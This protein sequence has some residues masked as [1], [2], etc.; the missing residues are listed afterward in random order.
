[1]GE[2]SKIYD[3]DSPRR[4]S[5]SVG[6][7]DEDPKL[8]NEAS[9]DASTETPNISEQEAQGE[10]ADGVGGAAS[11]EA[12]ALGDRVGSGYNTEDVK[13]LQSLKKF[14]AGATGGKKKKLI[15]AGLIGGG[16]GGLILAAFMAFLPLKINHIMENLQ[17]RF[18]ASS[19]SAVQ[20]RAERLLD[21]YLRDKVIPNLG[22]GTCS[23]SSGTIDKN[24]IANLEGDS[25]AARLFRGWRDARLENKLSEKY[26]IEITRDGFSGGASD[27]KIK[28][29]DKVSN[30]D[31]E[32]WRKDPNQGMWKAAGGRN[33]VRIKVRESFKEETL[34]KRVMYRF[35]VGRLL[36]EKYGI[37]RCVF[38]CKSKD[39]IDDWKDKKK[40]A[41]R[42]V[43]NRRVIIP[44]TQHLGFVLECI[45]D[46]ACDS[47]KASKGEADNDGVRR[48][49]IEKQIREALEK[50]G[51]EFT[52][53][54]VE[55]I[56]EKTIKLADKSLTAFIVEEVV[57]KIAGEAAGS[58]A[59][60]GLPVIGW[61]DLAARITAKAKSAGPALK[62]WKYE[63]I[64][65]QMVATYM[66][67]RTTADECKGMHCNV[68]L[69]G[70]MTNGVG[71]SAGDKDHKNQPAELAPLYGD[72][73]GE[74]IQKSSF[75]DVLSPQKAYAA[76]TGSTASEPKYTCD[77]KNKP[78]TGKLICPE[79]S[80]LT[81]GVIQKISDIFN[82]PPLSLLGQTADA[83]NATIGQILNL[84]NKL[85]D[86]GVGAV[87]A[88]I[89][90]I[91]P[92]YAD[93]KKMIEEQIGKI[94]ETIAKWLIPSPVSADMS[95]ART[96]DMLA[97]GADVAGNNDAHYGLGGIRLT[98]AQVAEIRADQ[99]NQRNEEFQRQP[100]FAR[101]FSTE[102]PKSLVSQM[103]MA[104]PSSV[105]RTAN[106]GV[107]GLLANPF[108]SLSKSFG[109]LLATK[110]TFAADAKPDP[111]GVVQYG[112]PKNSSALD[113]DPDTLTD[114]VCEKMDKDWANGRGEFAGTLI[115]DKETGTDVHTKENPCLLNKKAVAAAGGRYTTDVLDPE[116]Y[117]SETTSGGGGSNSGGGNN[118][119]YVVGDSLTNG[120]K[121][122]GSLTN[123]L[124]TAGWEVTKVQATDG[125]DVDR[126][127]EKIDLDRNEVS[128]A[129]TIAVMLGTNPGPDSP[130]F[131]SKIKLMVD[132]IH[133]YNPSA[134]IFW[135]NAKTQISNYDAVAAAV[136]S[137][138]AALKYTP[139]DW[140]AE[141]AKNPAKYPFAPDKIH[142]TAAGYLAKSDFL[143]ASLGPPPASTGGTGDGT[144]ASGTKNVGL[145]DGYEG[146]V[147]KKITLCAILGFPS[148]SEESNPRSQYYVNGADGN[149][150]VAADKSND[151]VN[152]FN[153]MKSDGVSPKASSSFRT[154][155]HQQELCAKD[156]KCPNGVY[157]DVAKPGTSRHQS[158][159]A[160]DFALTRV[161][162]PEEFGTKN[163]GKASPSNPRVAPGM[164]MWDWLID[165][166]GKYNLKQYWNEP[167]HWSHTGS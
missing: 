15:G 145:A 123:K 142:H 36:E 55:K 98:D 99:E 64:G 53:E 22:K 95:G 83:W 114:A 1:M 85:I 84:I 59:S 79:E 155:K 138:A 62:R 63:I 2:P 105:T 43:I 17:S 70:S 130:Q 119:V 158:G 50:S 97:G 34:W 61:I 167:W 126:S 135:M 109:S 102:S 37:R 101:M 107:T 73:L 137:Q 110:K 163:G 14:L 88:A 94:F 46:P 162:H 131:A 166:A 3:D 164:P 165:N 146:G 6:G 147:L 160:V 72:I 103:A 58:A 76:E 41:F 16:I 92:Q 118:A 132:K 31:V 140:R 65:T 136:S 75:L 134:K 149:V 67:Y 96:F 113:V 124:Q 116:D 159:D 24:C 77:D 4:A 38:A 26:G 106:T 141:V 48:D 154:M 7:G 45:I 11:R 128:R 10:A 153:A 74:P 5:G 81:N 143:V 78:D 29:N 47:D 144:C 127:L 87:E 52:E 9:G 148:S 60:K 89:S 42:L 28:V 91:F 19:E 12:D 56:V 112:F 156:D 20:T 150:L 108:T 152:M 82:Q 139:I 68:E 25:P 133:E 69:L 100:F 111:F 120:M 57:A 86:L 30:L 151:W 33:D 129:G 115:E 23:R 93:L 35:K 18:F 161:G 39:R 54:T 71:D 122:L 51:K 32:G 8:T 90:K 44:Y 104:T 125:I 117:E 21:K 40:G 27:Y 80:L 66:L 49:K 13:D 157:S 121:D